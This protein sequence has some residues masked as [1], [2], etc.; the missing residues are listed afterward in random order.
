MPTNPPLDSY[1][2]LKWQEFL[3][4]LSNYTVVS[5]CENYVTEGQLIR[6]IVQ[7]PNKSYIAAEEKMNTNTLMYAMPFI[8]LFLNSY[9]SPFLILFPTEL[10]SD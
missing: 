6:S 8:F 9:R 10:K 5:F 1:W 7:D 2:V 4:A 3:T